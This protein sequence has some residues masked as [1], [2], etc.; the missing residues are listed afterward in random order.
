ML[1]SR[2]K[3]VNVMTQ[4]LE[5]N[6]KAQKFDTLACFSSPFHPRTIYTHFF[7]FLWQRGGERTPLM[8]FLS[9]NYPFF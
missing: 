5:K 3:N 8:G 6:I 1:M 9:L 4:E 2:L 7:R